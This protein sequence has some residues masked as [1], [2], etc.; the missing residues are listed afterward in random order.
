MTEDRFIHLLDAYGARWTCW[1]QDEVAQARLALADNPHL[2]TLWSGAE[3]L[4]DLLSLPAVT[5][6]ADLR[7]R[8]LASAVGAGLKAR[9][10]PQGLWSAWTLWSGAGV[11]A[12]A[13]AGALLGVGL[14]QHLAAPM[15]A[16]T[17]FYQ[18]SLQGAD[19]TEVLGLEMASLE[20]PR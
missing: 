18:A 6:S 7:E 20:V 1:P 8:V 17:V 15:Q 19:D 9:R 14:A 13:V 4:D 11:M 10:R 16:E 12:T 5:A 3:A 2:Q